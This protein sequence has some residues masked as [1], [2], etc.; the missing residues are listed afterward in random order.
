MTTSFVLPGK[1]PTLPMVQPSSSAAINSV[2]PPPRGMFIGN[3]PLYASHIHSE[4]VDN[5]VVGFH[6]SSRKSL[7]FVPPSIQNSEIIVRPSLETIKEGSRR[8]ECTAVGYFLGKKPYFHHINEFVR[9][10]WPAAKAVNSTSNEFY[11]F[12]FKTT[13]AM[14]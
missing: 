5:I 2:A 6:N 12:Q 3:V 1:P 7:L 13:T 11:F 14:E 8:W 10:V 4:S 9:S